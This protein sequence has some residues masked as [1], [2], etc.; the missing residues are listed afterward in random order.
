MT[1]SARGGKP[2]KRPSPDAGAVTAGPVRFDAAVAQAGIRSG[3]SRREIAVDLW[4][5]N[6]VAADWHPGGWMWAKVRRL[7][8]HARAGSSAGSGGAD[9]GT[10]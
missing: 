7:V 8:R 1:A 5:E 2:A 3:K 6:R 9:A 4:G 10:P